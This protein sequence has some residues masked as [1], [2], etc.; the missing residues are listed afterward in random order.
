MLLNI[1]YLYALYELALMETWILKKIFF[2]KNLQ[3]ERR[4][5]WAESISYLLPHPN[6]IIRHLEAN[7]PLTFE[8]EEHSKFLK[9]Y[10][11]ITNDPH[12]TF[13]VWLIQ[14]KMDL[15]EG[16]LEIDREPYYEELGKWVE[17]LFYE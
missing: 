14:V 7:L 8:D 6:E 2:R 3:Y 16:W 4:P 9:K 5:Y 12:I 11:F 17:R 10:P 13:C 15:I 1:P